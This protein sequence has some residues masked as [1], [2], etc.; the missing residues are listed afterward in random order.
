MFLPPKLTAP[1]TRRRQ[2]TQNSPSTRPETLPA[3]SP[4]R[5]HRPAILRRGTRGRRNMAT[6]FLVSSSRDWR[7]RVAALLAFRDGGQIGREPRG[8]P[9]PVRDPPLLHR[10]RLRRDRRHRIRRRVLLLEE[11]EHERRHRAAATAAAGGGRRGG[12]GGLEEGRAGLDRER[13]HLL[14]GEAA[15]LHLG[16]EHEVDLPRP[17]LH[18]GAN[19]HDGALEPHLVGVAEE[20]RPLAGHVLQ[21]HRRRGWRRVLPELAAREHHPRR[22]STLVRGVA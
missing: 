3:S 11:R 10:H 12:C 15:A 22:R 16:G 13:G 21:C 17:Q 4:A 8:P 1:K 18:A 20:P 19:R 14:A 6:M 9:A 2:H 5:P 7:R